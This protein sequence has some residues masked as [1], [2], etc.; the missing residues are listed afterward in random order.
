MNSEYLW[1]PSLKS[2]E[3]TLLYWEP[4]HYG[5]TEVVTNFELVAKEIIKRWHLSQTLE[6]EKF[7]ILFTANHKYLKYYTQWNLD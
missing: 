6:G 5:N 4:L 3:S 2:L 1:K 7:D